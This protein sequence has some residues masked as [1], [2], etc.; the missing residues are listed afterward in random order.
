MTAVLFTGKMITEEIDTGRC[1]VKDL[2]KEFPNIVKCRAY[3]CGVKKTGSYSFTSGYD[4]YRT[5]GKGQITDARTGRLVGDINGPHWFTYDGGWYHQYIKS[6]GKL[7]G[8]Y[9]KRKVFGNERC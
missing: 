8:K 7:D 2:V 5:Y 6:D 4:R 3:L 1:T 9:P